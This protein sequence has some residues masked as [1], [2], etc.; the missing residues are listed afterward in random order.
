MIVIAL[1]LAIFS[2]KTHNMLTIYKYKLVRDII[3]MPVGAKVLHVGI[4]NKELYAWALVDP[5][6]TET[7]TLMVFGTGH[8]I[9]ASDTTGK[10]WGTHI[11]YNGEIVLHVWEVRGSAFRAI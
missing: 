11:L 7:D 3:K 9:N 4:Q 6:R 2:I 5:S 8:P 10:F 1:G